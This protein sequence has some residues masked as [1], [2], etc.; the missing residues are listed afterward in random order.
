M[1]DELWVSSLT[2]NIVLIGGRYLDQTVSRA[3]PHSPCYPVRLTGHYAE[4]DAAWQS[5]T[6]TRLSTS[7]FLGK[8]ERSAPAPGTP[9]QVW[10]DAVGPHGAEVGE[11][12]HQE[13]DF[14]F[15]PPLPA[16]VLRHFAVI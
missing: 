7:H 6:L 16:A 13:L 14:K 1:D 3:V 10:I 9:I 4:P 5:I 2:G 8:T 12:V 11:P 15:N